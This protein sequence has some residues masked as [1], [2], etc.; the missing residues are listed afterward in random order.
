[1]ELYGSIKMKREGFPTLNPTPYVFTEILPLIS[2]VWGCI[3]IMEIQ[4]FHFGTYIY[5][6]YKKD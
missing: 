3:W 4:T 2:M 5:D 6:D 1:M